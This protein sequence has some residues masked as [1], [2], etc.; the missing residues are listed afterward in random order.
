M[1]VKNVI[2]LTCISITLALTACS[3]D[4]DSDTDEMTQISSTDNINGTGDT[5]PPSGSNDNNDTTTMSESSA[6]E[7]S[8]EKGCALDMELAEITETEVYRKLVVN[9]S[10]G[11]TGDFSSTFSAHDS[12]TCAEPA[13]ADDSG[14]IT[15]TYI[16]GDEVTSNDG[17]LVTEVDLMRDAITPLGQETISPVVDQPLTLDIFLINE[18]NLYFGVIDDPDAIPPVRATAI[19][20]DELF[21]RQ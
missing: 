14:T 16:I 18:Q 12:A 5:T 19:D 15:G 7:G 2:T 8:W 17:L 21:V 20:F 9:F 1:T 6:L 3:S 11:T 10:G 4:S 13:I